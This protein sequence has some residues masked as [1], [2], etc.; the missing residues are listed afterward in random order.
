MILTEEQANA[1]L[2]SR[3]NL[4][5]RFRQ[6]REATANVVVIPSNRSNHIGKTELHL[7][8][9]TKVEISSRA[10]L[11]ETSRALGTE[12]GVGKTTV[13]YLAL[14]G[15]NGRGFVDEEK[16]SQ[17]MDEIQDVAMCK[18]LKSLGFLSD[19]KL[20]KASAKDLS[21]ISANMAK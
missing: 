9:E 10:R 15:S 2:D 5:N 19:E 3:R 16:V 20:L 1:R 4:V 17:R 8:E 13:E 11:G 14:G 21:A 12:F 7:P 18:L 6:E